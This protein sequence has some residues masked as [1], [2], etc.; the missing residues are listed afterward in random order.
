MTA[1]ALTGDYEKCLAAGMDNYI[2]K[3]IRLDK[4]VAA[5]K[6]SQKSADVEN[7]AETSEELT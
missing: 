4:L 2:S 3:P 1:H 5:L 6:E 7:E